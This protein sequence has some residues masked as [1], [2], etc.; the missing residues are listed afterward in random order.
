[1]VDVC[2]TP[3]LLGAHLATKYLSPNGLVV[4]TGAAAVFKEPQPE[5][6]GYS[7]AKTGVHSLALNLTHYFISHEMA[8]KVVTILPETIDT[9][10]NREAM[11]KSDFSKWS[12]PEQIGGLLRSWIDGH[13]VPNNGSFAVLKVKNGAVIPDFV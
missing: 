4:F 1:M 6:I 2:L 9:E 13:N 8:S 5:M 11:P 7:I 10:Q 3:T 12:K